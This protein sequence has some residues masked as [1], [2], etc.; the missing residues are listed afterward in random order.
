MFVVVT[1]HFKHRLFDRF[2]MDYTDN[3]NQD[4][5]FQIYAIIEKMNTKKA[6]FF[7]N[8]LMIEGSKVDFKGRFKDEKVFL[9]TCYRRTKC[10]AKKWK[11]LNGK[12]KSNGVNMYGKRKFERSKTNKYKKNRRMG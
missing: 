3:V 8:T 6:R 4:V 1:K 2:G 10:G 9:I 11:K 12:P 5:V 7:D